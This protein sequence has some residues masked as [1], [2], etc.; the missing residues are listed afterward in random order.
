MFDGSDYDASTLRTDFVLK[1][2]GIFHKRNILK[3]KS[4]YCTD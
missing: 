2:H 3:F 4:L 1:K